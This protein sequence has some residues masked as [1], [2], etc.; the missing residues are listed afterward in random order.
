MRPVSMARLMAEQVKLEIAADK[1]GAAVGTAISEM[2]M[3][4]RDF[5]E[6]SREA[7]EAERKADALFEQGEEIAARLLQIEKLL[8]AGLVAADLAA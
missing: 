5:G 6:Q 3:A 8:G 4:V 1:N 2:G 7:I